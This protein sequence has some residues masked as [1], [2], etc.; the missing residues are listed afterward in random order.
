MLEVGADQELNGKRLVAWDTYAEGR[1]RFPE[2]LGLLKAAG[3]LAVDLARYAEA[4]PL[5]ETALARDTTDAEVAVLPGPR[6][7]GARRRTAR[8]ARTGRARSTS[9]RSAPRRS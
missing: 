8:R 1:R 6:A 5:L 9:A 2:S 7:R 4:A 3:R